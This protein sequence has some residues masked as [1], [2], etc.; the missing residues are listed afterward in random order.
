[1]IT[2]TQTTLP[3]LQEY[4]SYLKKVWASR[5]VTNNGEFLQ[6]FEKKLQNYLQVKNL[7]VVA[8][9]TLALQLVLKALDLTGEV[10]TTPFTFPATTNV[11]IWEKLQPI[12]ADIDPKTFNLDPQEVKKKITKNTC[13]ILAVHVFGNPCYI[14]ELQ[15]IAHQYNLK[16]IFD[17]AHCFDVQYHNQ[18][19][20]QYG[21]AATLSFH[22]TKVFHTIEG[23]AIAVKDKNLFQKLKLLRDFGIKSE[24]M[25]ILPGI[26]AKMNE[27]QAIMGLCNLKNNKKNIQLRKKIYEQY[28]KT[29]GN[30]PK[31]KFQNLIAS[32][33]NYGYCPVCFKTGKIRNKIYSVLLKNKIGTRKY[34]FPL[35][36]DSRY[37]KQRRVKSDLKNASVISARIL[38]LPIYPDLKMKDIDRTVKIIKQNI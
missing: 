14:E 3:D 32:Q 2:V 12:F 27:F 37:L 13:A 19:I 15:A 20:L 10:I 36:T 7:L 18:S 8:N 21:D 9:G 30:D 22:A 31:I 1:M 24:G 17:A 11:I 35:T 28:K 23:G 5:W 16:L 25:F 29:L 38:C 6:L 33:Y 4:I 34:F 26:N